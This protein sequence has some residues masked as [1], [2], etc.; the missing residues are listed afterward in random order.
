MEF[1]YYIEFLNKDKGFMIDTI[2][3]NGPN[4]YKDCIN[5]GQQNL[6]NFNL[7]M[8]KVGNSE[9]LKANII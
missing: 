4:S 6:E 1:I 9:T 8:V 2:T 3:F 5:W 7:D